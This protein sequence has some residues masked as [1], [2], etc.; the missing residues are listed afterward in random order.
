MRLNS[1]LP[2]VILTANAVRI[3][4]VVFLAPFGATEK[5]DKL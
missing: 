5:H 3:L 4:N 2:Q 1:P